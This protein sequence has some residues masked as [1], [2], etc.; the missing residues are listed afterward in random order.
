MQGPD[1][2]LDLEGISVCLG[3]RD[4]QKSARSS[5][6]KDSLERGRLKCLVKAFVRQPWAGA[7]NQGAHRHTNTKGK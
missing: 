3:Q 4:V 6:R 1:S 5:G 2:D 7:R